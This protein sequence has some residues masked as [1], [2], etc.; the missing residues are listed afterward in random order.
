MW[1]TIKTCNIKHNYS[2]NVLSTK[3]KKKT[4]STSNDTCS[5]KKKIAKKD[6]VTVTKICDADNIALG[7]TQTT[8]ESVH[9][10]NQ[11]LGKTQEERNLVTF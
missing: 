1:F 10:K 9:S 7:S 5:S 4:R 2:Q 6:F 3:L 11:P 8:T